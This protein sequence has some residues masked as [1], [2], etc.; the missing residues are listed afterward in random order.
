MASVRNVLSQSRCPWDG[1]LGRHRMP[2]GAIGKSVGARVSMD[3]IPPF[4]Q[5]KNEKSILLTSCFYM[6]GIL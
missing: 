5:R 2:L 1:T 6:P 3:V 4:A